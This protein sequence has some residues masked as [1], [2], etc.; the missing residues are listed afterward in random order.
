MSASR[1]VVAKSRFHSLPGLLGVKPSSMPVKIVPH[2]HGLARTVPVTAE[3]ATHIAWASFLALVLSI[4]RCHLVPG[5]RVDSCAM[6]FSAQP[7]ADPILW[8]VFP[9]EL[10]RPAGLL[11]SPSWYNPFSLKEGVVNA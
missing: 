1:L 4:R 6:V 10:K 2:G 9:A 11:V 3:K 7:C 8:R 5:W